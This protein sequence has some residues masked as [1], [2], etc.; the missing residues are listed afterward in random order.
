MFDTH[1]SHYTDQADNPGLH[2]NQGFS[3]LVNQL[4][5]GLLE[6][7]R[8]KVSTNQ[9]AEVNQVILTNLEKVHQLQ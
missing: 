2:R 3:S 6:F 5:C 8:K 4:W 7:E 1:I 9:R